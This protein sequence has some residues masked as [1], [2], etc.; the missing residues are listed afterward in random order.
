ML[1]A[2]A[3]DTEID[4]NASRTLCF[5]CL[6]LC[7]LPVASH[8]SRGLTSPTSC[9]VPCVT[10]ETPLAQAQLHPGTLGFSLLPSAF[11]QTDAAGC[12]ARSLPPALHA[13]PPLASL[14]LELHLHLPEG[15]V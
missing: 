14:T 7:A 2:L 4:G 10:S 3:C 5:S 6:V 12:F 9:T 13:L 15:L 11:A 1:T 8:R